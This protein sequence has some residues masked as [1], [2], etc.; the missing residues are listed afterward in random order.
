MASGDKYGFDS[1]KLT[2]DGNAVEVAV[3]FTPRKVKVF[4]KDSVV[5]LEWTFPMPSASGHKMVQ[6]APP[7]HSFITSDGI[8]PLYET[9]LMSGNTRGF[10]I[11]A[12]SDLNVD[13]EEL[14]WEAWA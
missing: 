7:V 5:S 1:G 12:D 2:A 9:D 3:P 8:T 4:N 6:G 13:T 10:E 11:G 14:Y